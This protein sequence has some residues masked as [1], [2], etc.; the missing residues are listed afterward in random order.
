MGAGG[1]CRKEFDRY[2][3]NI[4]ETTDTTTATVTIINIAVM[5]EI[6]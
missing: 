4:I 2:K 3:D 5:I 6:I 1:G